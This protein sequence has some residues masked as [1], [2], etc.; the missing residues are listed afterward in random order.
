[1]SSLTEK[2]SGSIYPKRKLD[3]IPFNSQIEVIDKAIL[4]GSKSLLNSN[5][6][7]NV[8][9]SGYHGGHDTNHSHNQ[10]HQTKY[11]LAA[12][13]AAAAVQQQQNYMLQQSQQ[14]SSQ[15]Q[16]YNEINPYAYQ[17]Q[18]I[19]F[20]NGGD[21]GEIASSSLM[22]EKNI[23]LPYDFQNDFL[24]SNGSSNSVSSPTTGPLNHPQNAD[25]QSHQ[26]Q[27]QP[28]LDHQLSQPPMPGFIFE[29]MI[30]DNSNIKSNSPTSLQPQPTSSSNK[31][32]N[33]SPPNLLLS[34]ATMP[35]NNN[36]RFLDSPSLLP[37]VKNIPGNWSASNSNA[38]ALNQTS[39]WGANLNLSS[40]SMIPSNLSK[41]DPNSDN[42]I[43]I[44]NNFGSS[45]W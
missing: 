43:S 12:V 28:Q 19:N 11:A 41:F 10:N 1:M 8:H 24:A 21:R 2:E 27:S 3:C 42:K 33:S 13:T 16:S 37:S 5:Q 20:N 38:N 30:S 17:S 9:R 25:L 18:N 44:Q 23:Q 45:L 4:V 35:T 7:T 34:T 6:Y 31:T 40:S 22:L 15:S 39:I 32:E 26:F 14:Q 36:S 29:P